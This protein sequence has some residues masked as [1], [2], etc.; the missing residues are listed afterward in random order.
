MIN[1]AL[2]KDHINPKLFANCVSFHIFYCL[3][4]LFSKFR[5]SKKIF[6]NTN[7][8]SN[9]L[10]PDQARQKVGPDLGLNCLLKLLANDKKVTYMHRVKA[11][12]AEILQALQS[13][14]LRPIGIDKFYLKILRYLP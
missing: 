7:I 3:F 12:I 13:S 10:D 8:M 5:F 11:S 9:S 6:Q 2:H 14:I 4:I 1:I